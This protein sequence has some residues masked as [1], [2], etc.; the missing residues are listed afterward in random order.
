MIDS[1]E[2]WHYRT[3]PTPKQ[4]DFNVQLGCHF[5]EILEMLNVFRLDKFDGERVRAE[6]VIGALAELLKSGQ[7]NAEIVDRKEFLDSVADQ[8][9]TGMGAAYCAR[10]AP[11]LAIREVDKSNWSKFDENGDPIR[12]SNGKIIKGPN[13]QKP[14]LTGFY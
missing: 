4:E 11:G 7:V 6:Q 3:R 12:N 13:Y 9:V 2:A 14:N 5:E 10:M 8:V 1:I